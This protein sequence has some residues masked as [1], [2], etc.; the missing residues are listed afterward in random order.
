[1]ITEVSGLWVSWCEP[2]QRKSLSVMKGD[3]AKALAWYHEKTGLS[4]VLITLHPRNERFAGEAPG[5]V[6]VCYRWGCLLW[7]IWLADTEPKVSPR[8]ATIL[9]SILGAERGQVVSQVGPGIMSKLNAKK[10]SLDIIRPRVSAKRGPKFK[11][12][13]V[14]LVRELADQGLGA[15][16]IATRVKAQTGI[17]VSYKTIQRLLSGQRVLA[18]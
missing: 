17:E 5:G 4:A 11:V 13:P 10:T 18:I 6:E 7:E 15:W 1:M 8:I 16:A 2:L 12:L 14:E 3:I 9:P